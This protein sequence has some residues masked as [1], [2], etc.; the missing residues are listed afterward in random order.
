MKK[1]PDVLV[2][3]FRR[4][5]DKR[6]ISRPEQVEWFKWLRYYLDFCHKY[7]HSTRDPETEVL[8]LQKLSSKGQSD[9]QQKQA[10]ACIQLFRKVAKHFPAKGREQ[11]QAVEL[12]EWGEV[13][14]KLEEVIRFRQY[15]KTTGKTYRNWILQFQEFLNSKPVPEVDDRDVERFL[16]WLAV[17]RNVVS[18]TQDQAFN[19]LLFL[20]RYILKRPYELGDRVKRA[21]RTRYVP[22]VLSRPEVDDILDRM[23]DPFLLIA[24]LLYGCGLRLAET[25]RLRVGQLNLAH[26][27]LTIHRG[28]GR[29][30]RAVMLPDCLIEKLEEH[31]LKIRAKFDQDLEAGFAGSF[32]P[33]GSPVKWESRCKQ[34]PWQFFFP[35]KT[36]TLVPE[37]GLK[38]RYHVHDSQFSKSLRHAV[39]KSGISKKVG[40]HTLRHS[41]ASH[42]LLANYD[43][44]TI[45]EMMGHSDVKTTIRPLRQA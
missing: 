42:L 22:V 27:T 7:H 16:T 43:I 39:W 28:K 4:G 6:K 15:A 5:L 32:A 37:S 21:R 24:Q 36:L 40:A 34:W 10:S 18:T 11:D 31:L 41:F 33:E 19:A 3:E 35:A 14:V 2:S 25:L 38:K 45:Q 1:I 9:L 12:S 29:K 20:F 26:K 30:D 17:H 13:L 8:Y 23:E 44:R